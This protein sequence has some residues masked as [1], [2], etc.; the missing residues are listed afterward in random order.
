MTA[1]PIAEAWRPIPGFEGLYEVSDVGRVRSVDRVLTYA[2]GRRRRYPECI[3]RP[4]PGS[5]G[6][7]S[8]V[9]CRDGKQR[10]HCVHALVALAFVGPRPDGPEGDEIR[11]RDGDHLNNRPGNLAYGT[12]RENADDAVQHGTQK[13]VKK[14]HCV[15]DHPFDQA[16]TY[17]DGRGRRICRT[18][19]RARERARYDR[20]RRGVPLPP[21]RPAR[22]RAEVHRE[23]W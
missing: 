16:N 7:L 19:R 5:H 20:K 18:C 12:R 3:L 9:L 23:R 6:Y 1:T 15:N 2:D 21:G 4:A 13:E 22:Q 10:S 14:T 11:H 8:V 17:V